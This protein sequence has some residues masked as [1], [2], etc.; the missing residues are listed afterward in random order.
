MQ[1]GVVELALAAS[2]TPGPS[3]QRAVARRAA[4]EPEAFGFVRAGGGVEVLV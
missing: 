1:V 4:R 3:L 2:I